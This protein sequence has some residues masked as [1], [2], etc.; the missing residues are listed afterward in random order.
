[1]DNLTNR[2]EDT[3][4][5]SLEKFINKKEIEIP[6]DES[7]KSYSNEEINELSYNQAVMLDKRNTL[8]IFGSL[9]ITK[10]ELIYLFC[11]NSSVKIMLIG[12]YI[13]SLLINFFFNA[14]LY[15]DEVVSNK[16]HNNGQLDLIVT[17][18]LSIL[19]N[20][21]TSII[22]YILQYTKGLEERSELIKEI[23][24]KKYYIKNVNI[25]F[26]YIK[27]KFFCFFLCEILII[28][29]CF[30]YIVIFCI[31]YSRS[32]VSLMINYLTSLIEGLITSVIISFLILI[33]R[34]IGLCCFNKYF[35]NVSKYINSKF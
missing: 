11:S 27:I 26:K 22:C 35:Y 29:C 28:A 17:F 34:K 12:E 15:S 6:N 33:T 13:L 4:S 14:L 19:S 32:Q 9:I 24:I 5:P 31:I 10:I 18:V 8:L 1:M 21:I 3:Q 25:F 23:K 20:I 30:Y 16:Y 7:N 2:R